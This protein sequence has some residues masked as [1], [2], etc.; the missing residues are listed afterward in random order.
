MADGSGRRATAAVL[1]GWLFGSGPEVALAGGAGGPD[2][3][4]RPTLADLVDRVKDA[5]V[6]IRTTRKVERAQAADPFDWFFGGARRTVPR[7]SLGTGFL[8]D[9]DGHVLTNH[10]VIA[11]ADE[12]TVQF[13]DGREVPARRVGTDEPTDVGLLRIEPFQGMKTAPLGDS[14]QLRVGDWLYVIGNPFGYG[15]TVTAGI[16]S[17]K[18]R[19]LGHGPYDA[20][21]QTDASINPGNSGGPVFDLSGK[22]VG[23]A[24]AINP[25]GQGLGFAVPIATARQILPQLAAKGVVVRGWPGWRL[26]DGDDEPVLREV[27]RDSPALRSGLLAGDLLVEVAGNPVHAARD[28]PRA[29]GASPPGAEVTV[30]AE[31]DGTRRAVPLRLDDRDAWADRVSGSPVAIP[32]L[33]L[34]VRRSPPDAD[35]PDEGPLVVDVDPKGP[36]ARWLKPGDVVLGFQGERVVTGEDLARLGASVSRGDHVH[37]MVQRGGA[38]LRMSGAVR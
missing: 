4:P 5:V 31:R 21:V 14:D 35:R 18:G 30:V 38:V 23:I 7:H 11:E 33:G 32:S 9:A 29:L 10:H 16:V 37:W 24:T 2:F 1:A 28:V 8:V 12:I 15:H 27:Y 22:V 17:A 3:P 13:P 25:R 36:A 19:V 20:F 6:N 34:K 26:G